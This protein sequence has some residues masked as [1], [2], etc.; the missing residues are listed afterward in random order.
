MRELARLHHL[1]VEA[2]HDACIRAFQ[3]GYVGDLIVLVRKAHPR[4]DATRVS[5]LPLEWR[6]EGGDGV[7]R[8]EEEKKLR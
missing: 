5:V 2:V 4:Q 3:Y 7:F 1:D 6:T 8:V